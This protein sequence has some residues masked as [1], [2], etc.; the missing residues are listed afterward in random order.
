MEAE[1]V[2]AVEEGDV[3]VVVHGVIVLIVKLQFPSVL[4]GVV[5]RRLILVNCP[6]VPHLSLD[7][8]IIHHPRLL[9]I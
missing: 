7:L 1:E 2:V 8:L 5:L 6:R 9:K 4:I 3:V